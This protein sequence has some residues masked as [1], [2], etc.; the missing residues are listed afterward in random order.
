MK[1]G[2]LVKNLNTGSVGIVIKLDGLAMVHIDW[3]GSDMARFS[4]RVWNANSIHLEVICE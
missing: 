2:S 3:L 1:V 4:G